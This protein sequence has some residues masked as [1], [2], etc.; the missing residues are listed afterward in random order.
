MASDHGDA[1]PR[2]ARIA[3]N[4]TLFREVNERLRELNEMFAEFTGTFE[5][6]CECDDRTCVERLVLYPSEYEQVRG[7]AERFVVHPAHVERG[8]ERVL[9]QNQRY[10]V[11]EKLGA[12]AE[13]ARER[14]PRDH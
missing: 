4:E 11:V 12:T 3:Q 9:E 2:S 1:D 5:I 6:V 7:R 8:V 13:V 14:D 10:A